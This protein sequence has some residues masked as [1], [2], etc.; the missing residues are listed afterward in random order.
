MYNFSLGCSR[1]YN[2][3]LR[4]ATIGENNLKCVGSGDLL[5]LLKSLSDELERNVRVQ[6]SRAKCL[7][8][9]KCRLRTFMNHKYHP[10]CQEPCACLL[11]L[12]GL[13]NVVSNS[14]HFTWR[15][16]SS[17][18]LKKTWLVVRQPSPKLLS[19]SLEENRVPW[20]NWDDSRRKRGQLLVS[21]SHLPYPFKKE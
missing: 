20:W 16:N 18:K 14:L 5:G 7:R 6:R 21:V 3:I 17:R 2:S 19:K 13:I 15:A 1:R 11:A 9:C 10:Y 4:I 12:W 8:L